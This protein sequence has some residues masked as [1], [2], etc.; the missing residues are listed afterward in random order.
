MKKT[1]IIIIS[2]FIFLFG[3]ASTGFSQD[4]FIGIKGG[5]L[6]AGL[7]VE[8]S[9]TDKVSARVGINYFPYEYSGT[10]DDIDYNFELDLMTLGVFLD[11][12]PFEGS[13]RLTGGLM[14]NNNSLDSTAKSAAT[15]DI[16][17]QTYTGSDV[18]TLSGKIDFNEFVPYVGLGWNTAFGK[19]R[20]WGFICE[21]GV[22]FQ[23][24]PK[25]DL[26]ATGPIASD[27]AF[28]AD[29]AKEENNLQD[30]LDNF[31]YYPNISFGICYRF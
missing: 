18:G 5:L 15:F 21:L 8:R 22:I 9:L 31:E 19:D 11:W 13:F 30:D 6:G 29:L 12:H 3:F 4:T 26:T 27:S 24:S 17:D 16:G 23:G 25:A 28:M 7:E 1:A 2:I 14:Y 20:H 10:E